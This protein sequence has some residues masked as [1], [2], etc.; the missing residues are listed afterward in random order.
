M[1]EGVVAAIEDGWFQGE[2]A[3]AAYQF[4]RKLDTQRWTLVG[5]NGYTESDEEATPTLYIDSVVEEQQLKRL[6]HVKQHRNDDAVRAALRRVSEEARDTSVNLVPAFIE[7]AMAYVT[8][9][10]VVATLEEVFGSWSEQ[11][12]A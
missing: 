12:R 6:A 1:L 7:A 5:V 8:V 2:I 9:G 11:P 4:Q 10:E 3:E